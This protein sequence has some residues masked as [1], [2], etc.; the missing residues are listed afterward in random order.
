MAGEC[1][2][3]PSP[4]AAGGRAG[5]DAGLRD[6]DERDPL[7][8]ARLLVLA[9]LKAAERAGAVVIDGEVVVGIREGSTRSPAR[10]IG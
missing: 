2:N 5:I 4:R 9:D 1:G 10:A 6:I 8:P 7:G 3:A